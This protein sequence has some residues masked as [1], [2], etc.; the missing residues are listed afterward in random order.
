M[1]NGEMASAIVGAKGK[2]ISAPITQLV[3]RNGAKKIHPVI[4]GHVHLNTISL[5]IYTLM[6]LGA[7]PSP[8]RLTK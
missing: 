5:E 7:P 2:G 8:P 3:F 1:Q 6:S 4:P